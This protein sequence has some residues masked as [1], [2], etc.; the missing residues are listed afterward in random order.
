MQGLSLWGIFLGTILIGVTDGVDYS[1]EVRVL[2]DRRALNTWKA[3]VASN[4]PDA[5]KDAVTKT[6]MEK[7]ITAAF[8]DMNS[9]F[10]GL[11][12][13]G[14]NIDARIIG[15]IWFLTEEIFTGTSNVKDA[16]VV[17]DELEAWLDGQ[18]M[19]TVDHT[20]LFTGFDLT[21][22]G[23]NDNL[24]IANTGDMCDSIGSLSAAEA[25]PGGSITATITHE[26]GHSLSAEHDGDTNA[27]TD[28][29]IMQA[30]EDASMATKDNFKF[31]TCSV[32]YFKT[33][34]AAKG[35]CLTQTTAVKPTSPPLGTIY[36]PDQMCQFV[37]GAQSHVCRGFY[38]PGDTPYSSICLAVMCQEPGKDTCTYIVGADG[39]VC[40]QGKRCSLGNCVA[41][42]SLPTGT[43]TDTCPLGDTPLPLADLN[44]KMC[45]QGVADDPTV[46]EDDF[47][48][49]SCC[50]SCQGVNTNAAASTPAT[51]TQA[52]PAP[53]PVPECKDQRRWCRRLRRPQCYSYEGLCCATCKK[54]Q[55]NSA[56]KNCKYGDKARWCRRLGYWGCVYNKQVCCQK[57][58]S[59]QKPVWYG[60]GSGSWD[61]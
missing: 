3:R 53:K 52:T 36:T 40:G 57:C 58:A 25:I 56:D 12:T 7:Y 15:D 43:A 48:R 60:S 17:L 14:I 21:K 45:S 27:C 6:A 54:L 46:C 5:Q 34:L 55:I 31:S 51:D 29:F 16:G 28:G 37:E 13:S 4:V 42:A 49:R 39:F 8:S 18:S 2:V 9:I 41:D 59:I 10:S 33:F 35:Q 11:S 23:A 38:G 20:M 44:G 26:L 61:D 32:S 24:G 47:I 50:K 19:P 22:G 1:I 30:S